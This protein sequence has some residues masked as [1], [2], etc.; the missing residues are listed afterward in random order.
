MS[1]C[2]WMLCLFF[3][4]A[5]GA[6]KGDSLNDEAKNRRAGKSV[7]SNGSSYLDEKPS[8]SADGVQL[9]FISS[10][11][12]KLWAYNFTYGTSVTASKIK[13]ATE[14]DQLVDTIEEFMVLPNGSSEVFLA[15]KGTTYTLYLQDVAGLNAAVAMTSGTESVSQIVSSSDSLQIAF[16]KSIIQTDGTTK[17]RL[18]IADLSS[19][20]SP[21]VYPVSDGTLTEQ[22]PVFSYASAAPYQL[23]S[24]QTQADDKGTSVISRIYSTP[25]TIASVTPTVLNKDQ[26]LAAGISGMVGSSYVMIAPKLALGV[27]NTGDNKPVK[28]QPAHLPLSGGD[29]TALDT[30]GTEVLSIGGSKTGDFSYWLVRNFFKDNDGKYGNSIV[31]RNESSATLSIIQPR[32]ATEAG[33]WELAPDA[34]TKKRSDGTDGDLDYFISRMQFSQNSTVDTY[35]LIYETIYSGDPEIRMLRVAN[36]QAEFVD[37]SKCTKDSCN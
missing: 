12:G 9:G 24:Q 34:I 29:V 4:Q 16:V 21:Q 2:F 14:L 33:K 1:A 20:T 37:I 11:S 15:R 22:A 23:I 32:T 8:M 25:S 17:T 10:R 13:S 5:C 35:Q 26:T 28:N 27:K 6:K 18:Y 7:S 3:I 36:G 31:L 19:L 30:P